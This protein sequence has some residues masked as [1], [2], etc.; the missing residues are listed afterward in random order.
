MNRPADSILQLWEVSSEG[1]ESS[2]S[3]L[4]LFTIVEMSEKYAWQN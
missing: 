4:I 1:M 2:D 3:S